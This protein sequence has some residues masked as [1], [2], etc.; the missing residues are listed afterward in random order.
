MSDARLSIGVSADAK[1]ASATF[2][3]LATDIKAVGKESVGVTDGVAKVG[4]ALEKLAKAPDTPMALARATA[5]AKVEIDE[6]RAALEKT[7]ASAEK[8]KAITAALAQADAAMQKSI[9]RAG[10]LGE[11]Q[12]EVK[13]KMGLTAKGAE[14]LGNSF[15]SLD[16]IM[17]KMA[18]SSSAASQNIAKIG[19]SMMAAATAFKLGYDAGTK[20]NTFLQEHGNYLEKIIDLQIRQIDGLGTTKDLLTALPVAMNS[21]LKAQ[22][23]L[24]KETAAT[25]DALEKEAGGWKDLDKVRAEAMQRA[26]DISKRYNQLKAAGKD[27][28]GDM[29]LQA[30]SIKA[31]TELL[32]R[33]G[34]QFADMP[35]GFEK[36]SKHVAE[37]ELRLIAAANAAVL[38]GDGVRG[39]RDTL[40]LLPK[41]LKDFSLTEVMDGLAKAIKSARESGDG[42]EVIL[43]DYSRELA[44]LAKA[45]REA[46][47]E[48]L[49]QFRTK[50]LDLVPAHQAATIA[51]SDQAKATKKAVDE[52]VADYDR[53]AAAAA[54]SR[55]EQSA[56]R[57]F[58]TPETADNLKR[59]QFDAV[60]AA[61]AAGQFGTSLDTVAKKVVSLNG[62]LT[63]HQQIWL[64]VAMASDE[65][66]AALYRQIEATRALSDT[67]IASLDAARGW[68]DYLIALKEGYESGVTSLGSYIQQL[69]AFKSQLEQMF[70]GVTG[71][72][73]DSLNEMIQLIETLLATAGAGGPES[74]GGGY[75]GQ[76][77]RDMNKKGK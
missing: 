31:T 45:A 69:V 15:N 36:A 58:A 9:A 33:L 64:S 21:T 5:K 63:V 62:Q 4:A 59:I 17:G 12:E 38:T 67:Q 30:G 18:D 66:T 8:M 73:A 47:N 55:A 11:A 39:L 53:L 26:D 40:E 49:A 23:D 35:L 25:L 32:Q 14:S 71:A 41:N 50:I 19:F 77:Q 76:F 68:S 3:E 42:W 24:T 70:A 61:A 60:G 27:W 56:A 75:A 10:K 2:K 54:K 72:A 74:R 6:L 46:G 1:Q 16:G 37:F 7:P 44:A 51:V 13:Q 34:V 65:A 20:F 57:N 22:Q 43:S 48:G 52:I 28:R 29:E